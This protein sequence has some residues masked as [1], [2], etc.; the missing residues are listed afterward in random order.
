[1]ESA[2]NNSDCY[3]RAHRGR[4]RARQVPRMVDVTKRLRPELD[5]MAPE[6]LA[7]LSGEKPS[8][9]MPIAPNI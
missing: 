9:V 5:A 1:M 2:L 8:P 7:A 4:L 6:R 3:S